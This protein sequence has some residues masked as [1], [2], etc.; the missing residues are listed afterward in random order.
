MSTHWFF[1]SFYGL[2]YGFAIP[3]QMDHPALRQIKLNMVQQPLL[4]SAVQP[5]LIKLIFPLETVVH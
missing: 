3:M 2:G 1:S 4:I 5:E